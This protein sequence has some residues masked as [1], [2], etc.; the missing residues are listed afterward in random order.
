CSACCIGSSCRSCR[1]FFF[2]FQ[3]ED[4]I[5]YRNVTGVQTCALPICLTDGQVIPHE[6]FPFDFM[7]VSDRW[8]HGFG[9]ESSPSDPF[10][11]PGDSG[12]G[13]F[14]GDTAVG[15]ISGGGP[16]EW[17]DGTPFELGWVAALDYSL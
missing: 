7:N 11:Q 4:G 17:D 9:V 8:V 12:G 2:F 16:A 15:V 1:A 10:S 13:V 5:R 6:S 14:Q 3:A